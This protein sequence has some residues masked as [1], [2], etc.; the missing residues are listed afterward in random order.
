MLPSLDAG[1]EKFEA[2]GLPVKLKLKGFAGAEVPFTPAAEDWLA[3]GLLTGAAEKLKGGG[4][5]RLPPAPAPPPNAGN[6]DVADC[7]A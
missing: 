5:K 1:A 7:G 4:E 6:D 2:E 3:N